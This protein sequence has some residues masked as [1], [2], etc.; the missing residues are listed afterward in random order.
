MSDTNQNRNRNIKSRQLTP[1][2]GAPVQEKRTDQAKSK[3]T[4]NANINRKKGRKRKKVQSVKADGPGQ[5]AN[6][7]TGT[8]Q[9]EPGK[10]QAVQKRNPGQQSR[11]QAVAR[12]QPRNE[13]APK[14]QESQKSLNQEI[15]GKEKNVATTEQ[16]G[17]KRAPQK[18]KSHSRK[19]ASLK[20][21]FDNIDEK[22]IRAVETAEDIRRDIEQLERDIRL[23]IDGIQTINLDL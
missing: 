13:R 2:D 3:N 23:D 17:Q 7:Q 5:A 4:R 21:R 15:A 19:Q 11:K 12:E 22:N 16:T 8:K 10:Q 18:E 6:K 1:R 9:T 14:Q 20:R